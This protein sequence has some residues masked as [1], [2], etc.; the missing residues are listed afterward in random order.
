MR[1][2]H[3]TGIG[4][5]NSTSVFRSKWNYKYASLNIRKCLLYS[6]PLE[7]P[8][9]G[10]VLIHHHDLTSHSPIL[11]MSFL[12][13]QKS[14]CFP[15]D[16]AKPMSPVAPGSMPFVA[17]FR[18]RNGTKSINIPISQKF[19][20]VRRPNHNVRIK[21]HEYTVG[22]HLPYRTNPAGVY[23]PWYIPIQSLMTEETHWAMHLHKVAKG[24]NPYGRSRK[25]HF[26]CKHWARF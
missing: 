26:Y 6:S 10:F 14:A 19:S 15:Q 16:A 13:T 9:A 17:L 25:N 5:E 3:A 4:A 23:H 2:N 12:S 22:N 1:F 8:D 7:L 18:L 20:A 24:W 11:A 21:Y